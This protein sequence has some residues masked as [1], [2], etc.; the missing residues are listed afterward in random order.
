MSM[1]NASISD[2]CIEKYDDLKLNKKYKFIIFKLSDNYKEFE[3]EEA[4]EESD[5][6]VFRQKLLDAKTKK[7]S[8]GFGPGPRFAIYDFLYNLQAG[9]G[10][11]TKIVFL[12]W[13]PD[14]ADV[15]PK[16]IYASSKEALKRSFNGIATELQ[17]NDAEDI[18]YKTIVNK[19]SKGSA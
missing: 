9:E 15:Q 2:E 7:K 16:M 17:A 10:S 19:I 6:E 8:G 18:E 4:S 3:V 14:T 11:R 12:A 1:T 5:W 13:S